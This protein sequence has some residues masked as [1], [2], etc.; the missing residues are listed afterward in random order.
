MERNKK[1]EDKRKKEEVKI[2]PRTVTGSTVTHAND[3][4]SNAQSNK[5]NTSIDNPTQS[6]YGSRIQHFRTSFESRETDC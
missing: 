2:I 3:Q 4:K 6:A 1:I 5:H